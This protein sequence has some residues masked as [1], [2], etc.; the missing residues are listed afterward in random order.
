MTSL[1]IRKQKQPQTFDRGESIPFENSI[2][3]ALREPGSQK[4]HGDRA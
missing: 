2:L 3:I 4:E 1:E